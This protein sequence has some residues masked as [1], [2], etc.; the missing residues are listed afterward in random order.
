M[1]WLCLY[2][3]LL[4]L[5]I[6]TR[7]HNNAPLAAVATE[8]NRILCA[9]Q[10]ALDMGI[11][12]GQSVAT[13]TALGDNLRTI[14]RDAGRESQALDQLAAW[15]YRFSP[16]VSLLPPNA[17]VLEVAGSLQLFKGLANLQVQIND[18]L[19]DRGYS[20]QQGLGHTPKAAQLFAHSSRKPQFE[21]SQIIG[22]PDSQYLGHLKRIPLSYLETSRRH[23]QLFQDMGLSQL[24]EILALPRHAIGKRFGLEF[25]HYLQK[26]IGERPDPQQ[27]INLKPHFSSE[28]F[29]ID[30]IDNTGTL[31]FPAKRLLSELCQFL[32][33]RQ[34]ACRQLNWYFAELKQ[35][36]HQLTISLSRPQ[37]SLPVFLEMTRIKFENLVLD[38][39]IHSISLCIDGF[40][41]ATPERRSL[42]DSGDNSNAGS[43][44]LLLDRLAI[45]LGK[46]AIQG[47]ELQPEHA[48]E[49][50][51]RAIAFDS[52]KH[53]SGKSKACH[54]PDKLRPPWLFPHPVPVQQRGK[55]LYWQGRLTLL[56]GPE[57]I[58]CQWWSNPAVQRDYFIA[59]HERGG[60]YW[61]F[62]DLRSRRWFLHGAF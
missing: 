37:N 14:A 11:R 32:K 24:G 50:A 25:L 54:V 3:P 2:F 21:A 45:R 48:P 42:F 20:Y 17:L 44:Q 26:I 29:Y 30:G 27:P 1:L 41:D 9:N 58:E 8:K 12:P 6:F 47:I 13:A 36:P 4:P 34:L 28:L 59:R 53:G 7:A 40:S 61:L 23:M 33:A 38:S 16:M 39:T 46:H 49:Q 35:R 31:L 15:C 18:G 43:S 60:I 55:T 52:L 5:E 22:T 56:R 51:W 19:T 62:R 57:R 10:Q